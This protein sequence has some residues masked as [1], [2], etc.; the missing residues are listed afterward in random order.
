MSAWNVEQ[1][2]QMALPPCLVLCQFNVLDKNIL[3]CT[4]YQRSGDVGLGVPFNIASYAFLTHMIANTC[5]L[6]ATELTHYISNAHIYESH[7]DSLKIQT[8]EATDIFGK[9]KHSAIDN[10]HGNILVK[11]D[12]YSRATMVLNSELYK[13]NTKIF[14]EEEGCFETLTKTTEAN[15]TN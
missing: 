13:Y 8:M 7:I 1:L 12:F 9:K 5:K 3:Y 11:G 2:N 4:L 15:N 14:R 10:G 6:E